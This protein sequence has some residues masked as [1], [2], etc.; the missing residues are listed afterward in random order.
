MTQNE[1]YDSYSLLDITNSD[2]RSR[3]NINIISYHTQPTHLQHDYS[4]YCP[5]PDDHNQTGMILLRY[6]TP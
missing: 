5:N 4:H 3:E 2:F 6:K 1:F